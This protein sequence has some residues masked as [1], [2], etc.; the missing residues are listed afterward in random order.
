MNAFESPSSIS[1]TL[2]EFLHVPYHT[3]M[4][5]EDIV[6][7]I[8]SYILGNK[9]FVDNRMLLVDKEL[10]PVFH[11]PFYYKGYSNTEDSLIMVFIAK[12]HMDP[13]FIKRD[14]EHR[15]ERIRKNYAATKLQY[16]YRRCKS[17]K[18]SNG[19]DGNKAHFWMTYLA[20]HYGRG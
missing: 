6:L 2:A 7:A 3:K 20:C 10:Q 17:Q 8:W 11:P 18:D 16:W 13:D 19:S 9:L 12:M 5:E 15:M 1:P 4:D 14:I